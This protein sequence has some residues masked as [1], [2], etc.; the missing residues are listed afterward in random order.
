MNKT[1]NIL[2]YAK[3]SKMLSNGTAPIYLRITIDGKQTEIAAKRYILPEKW[4]SQAQK[5]NGNSEEVKALDLYLKTFEQQV[6]EAQH[7]LLKDKEKVTTENL[8]NK[9]LGVEEKPRTIVPIFQDHNNQIKTLLGSEFSKGTLT[10]YTTA[11]HRFKQRHPTHRTSW[12]WQNN[13][14]QPNEIFHPK[15]AAKIHHKNLPRYQL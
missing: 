5:V 8:K 15:T 1:F 14:H 3:K 11:K 7:C 2:F 13:T 12:L 6:Y 4:N 9:L 10:R